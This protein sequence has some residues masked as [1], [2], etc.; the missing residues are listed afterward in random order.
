M[1]PYEVF[2]FSSGAVEERWTRAGP[3]HQP[4]Q[5]VHRLPARRPALA[6][7]H[8]L[9]RA[10]PRA[11]RHH[12]RPA[13][14]GRAPGRR[15]RSAS[16]ALAFAILGHLRRD[17]RRRARD[18]AV[19]RLRVAAVLRL[20]V[21]QVRAAAP[22]GPLPPRRHVVDPRRRARV[23]MSGVDPV[24]VTEYSIVLS[25]AA[26]PLTYFP[27]LVDRQRPRLHGRARRT[28]GS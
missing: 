20:A 5:R 21:G 14:P 25:A 6:R 27:I 24:K 4:G 28:G 22:G 19:G 7:D 23:R 15:R 11:A 1:T 12:G 26:L 18:G 2:F 16:S 10:R 17:L 3:R 13:V 8:G 9:R